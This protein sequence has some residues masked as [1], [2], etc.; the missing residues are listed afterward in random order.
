MTTS[1]PRRDLT[2]RKAVVTGGTHGMGLGIVRALADR[3]AQV[4]ATG[5][6]Q[7]N[8]QKANSEFEGNG[9][10]RFVGSD[11]GSLTEIAEL[12]DTV[13]EHLGDVDYLFVNHGIAELELLPRRIRVNTVAPGFIMTPTMGVKGLTDEQRRDFVEEGNQVTPLRRAGT[14]GEIAQAA[15]FLAVEATFTTGAEIPVDGGYAQ[16]LVTT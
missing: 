15:L 12:A 11:A 5:R 8:V 3:G 14:V 7:D 9:E 2:D 13:D 16:G 10:V 4:L 6:N 1:A